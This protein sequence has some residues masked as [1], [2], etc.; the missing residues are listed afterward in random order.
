MHLN[1]LREN[2]KES[3][4]SINLKTFYIKNEK[5]INFFV[6]FIFSMK[7]MS[8][9]SDSTQIS[10]SFHAHYALTPDTKH[11]TMYMLNLFDIYCILG[12]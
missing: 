4:K 1:K 5:V 9:F 2:V 12:V 8:K 11:I 3:P 6:N 7:M 10:I